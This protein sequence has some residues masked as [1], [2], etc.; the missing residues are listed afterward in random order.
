MDKNFEVLR[1]TSSR[2]KQNR[3]ERRYGGVMTSYQELSPITIEDDDSDLEEQALFDINKA[4]AQQV[5]L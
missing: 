4:R 2:M 1:A 5:V 3:G